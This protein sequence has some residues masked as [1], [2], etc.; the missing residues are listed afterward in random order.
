MEDGSHLDTGKP[1]AEQ[2]PLPVAAQTPPAGLEGSASLLAV[3]PEVVEEIR[4]L[5]R[6]VQTLEAR[7]HGLP[8]ASQW[9]KAQER[10]ANLTKTAQLLQ[11]LTL[12]VDKLTNHVFADAVGVGAKPPPS[13][14][15]ATRNKSSGESLPAAK[16]KKAK[17]E[18]VAGP[19]KSRR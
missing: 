10:I 5:R 2:L 12:D 18:P 14:A 19:S 4:S 3:I 7:C 13:G 16:G 15:A 11:Q 8:T 1:P 6:S 9:Q 17:N